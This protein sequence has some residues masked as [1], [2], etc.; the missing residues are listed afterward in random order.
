MMHYI[1]VFSRHKLQM[2]SFTIDNLVR[3]IDAFVNHIDIVKIGFQP[4]VMKSVYFIE[5]QYR[6]LE[7]L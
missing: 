1:K 3:F 6:T 2:S 5:K 4:K 7:K